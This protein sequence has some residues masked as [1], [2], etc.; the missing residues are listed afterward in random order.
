MPTNL[1]RR[2]SIL[3]LA[4]AASALFLASA[5]TRADAPA[6]QAFDQATFDAALTSGRPTLIEIHA[7]WCPTCRAQ[8]A[9]FETLLTEPRYADLLV[10]RVDFDESKDVVRAFGAQRQSTLIVFAGGKE[11][12]R[13]VGTTQP[14][15]LAALLDTAY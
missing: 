4:A 5:P 7:D 1:I 2:R 13:G 8:D 12:G 9:V 14:K 11:V 6:V 3:A 10:L 15:R